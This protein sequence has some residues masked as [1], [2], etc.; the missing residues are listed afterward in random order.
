M[1]ID[2]LKPGRP[3]TTPRPPSLRSLELSRRSVGKSRRHSSRPD[4]NIRSIVSRSPGPRRVLE[5]LRDVAPTYLN[6]PGS[7]PLQR[8]P[9]DRS[10]DRWAALNR[11]CCEASAGDRIA[12]TRE[13]PRGF[14]TSGA[15][16][17]PRGSKD[18]KSCS[19][20]GRRRCSD[21]PTTRS[22]CRPDR[23]HDSWS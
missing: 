3:T 14:E 20:T 11:G 2:R 17:K 8:R 1:D 18:S 13:S 22:S 9:G 12:G 23:R 15:V 7:V 6:V 10:H 4:Q 19:A 21:D 16:A 5:R